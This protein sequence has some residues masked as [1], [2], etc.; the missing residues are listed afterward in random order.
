MNIHLVAIY[1]NSQYLAQRDVDEVLIPL[2]KAE[3]LYFNHIL[4]VSFQ[5]IVLVW[6]VKTTK[7][8]V[9]LSKHLRN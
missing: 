9:S 3:S 1:V 4:M 8:N 7:K 5:T 6:R 2:I